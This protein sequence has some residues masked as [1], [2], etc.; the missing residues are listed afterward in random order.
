MP[1]HIQK[2]TIHLLKTIP[3][4]EPREGDPHYK[5]FNQTRDRM[6]K[7][8]L[9]KCWIGDGTCSAGPIEL[10]H[11]KV[12]FCFQNGVDLTKFEERFPEF[13]GK[14]DEEF[15]AWIEGPGN[16]LGL[17]KK[18][19]TGELGIHRIPYPDW[20]PLSFW[21]DGLVPPAKVEIGEK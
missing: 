2:E 18:H 3:D 9:L 21:Q 10:H 15:K 13:V 6:E 1:D 19:H 7:Q 14:T 12:E 17:C 5:I 8:G 4:H 16:L 20:E 11:S